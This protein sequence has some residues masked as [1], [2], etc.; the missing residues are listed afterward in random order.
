MNYD[1]NILI[2]KKGVAYA[3]PNVILT[4]RINI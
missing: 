4:N 1:K 3:T 2:N